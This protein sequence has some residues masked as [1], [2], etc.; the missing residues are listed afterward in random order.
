MKYQESIACPREE[1]AKI[2]KKIV[3][4]VLGDRCTVEGNHVQMPRDVDFDVKVKYNVDED[5][6]SLTIKIAWEN[7][8]EE[9]EECEEEREGE[10]F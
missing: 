1:L 10:E 8:V 9:V 7:Y 4:D 6:G 2:I 5:G 3:S